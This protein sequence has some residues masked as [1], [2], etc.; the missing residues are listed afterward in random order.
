YKKVA[1]RTRPVATTLPEEFRIVRRIPSDPLA[2][3]PILLTQPPDFEPGEC[4]TRERM[5][6]MPVNKDGSLWPEE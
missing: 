4:Y 2:D 6:A 1:N 5:E 3:L